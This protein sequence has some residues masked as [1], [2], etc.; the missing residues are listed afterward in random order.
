MEGTKAETIITSCP[1]CVMQLQRK[2]TNVPVLHLI[3]VI[4]EAFEGDNNF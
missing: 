4:E 3:E 2:I 1:G